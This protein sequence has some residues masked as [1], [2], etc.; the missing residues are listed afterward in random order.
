[1]WIVVWN[2][3]LFSLLTSANSQLRI[4]LKMLSATKSGKFQMTIHIDYDREENKIESI[5]ASQSNVIRTLEI[6]VLPSSWRFLVWKIFLQAFGDKWAEDRWACLQKWLLRCFVV[7]VHTQQNMLW[8][9]EVE[10]TFKFNSST[11]F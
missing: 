8:P 2:L 1:M 7:Y 10:L 11:F 6:C 4:V 3:A 5:L 9:R